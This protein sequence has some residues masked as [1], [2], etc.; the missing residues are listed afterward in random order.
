MRHNSNNSSAPPRGNTSDNIKKIK[1]QEFEEKMVSWGSEQVPD[2][3]VQNL[4][5]KKYDKLSKSDMEK[6]EDAL[7]KMKQR[8]EKVDEQVTAS[9][10]SNVVTLLIA[11]VAVAFMLV[12]SR[13]VLENEYL[14]ELIFDTERELGEEVLR[15][16]NERTKIKQDMIETA[17]FAANK[18]KLTQ[19]F[20][21]IEEE[22]KKNDTRSSLVLDK[23]SKE[24][25]AA[26]AASKQQPQ[27]KNKGT[28]KWWCDVNQKNAIIAN[29]V[30]MFKIGLL[31]L[32][33]YYYY[34]YIMC[35]LRF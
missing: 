5:D 22:T 4:K 14:K 21:K 33:Y 7:D 27:E 11:A 23:L 18:D 9:S 31:L 24:A 3:I 32:F 25:N 1:P 12:R 29:T 20:A 26:V 35:D 16:K 30:I 13:D 2:R 34:Y 19:Y 8:H 10:T 17:G 6:L 15:L 28:L